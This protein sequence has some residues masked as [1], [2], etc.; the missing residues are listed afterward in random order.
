MKSYGGFPAKML[1][2]AVPEPFFSHVMPEISDI[3]E[4]K[5]TLTI[6]RVLYRK[7]GSLRF[8]TMGELSGDTG[9]MK[10]L[11]EEAEVARMTLAAALDKAVERGTILRMTVAGEA[12]SVEIYFLNTD[13]DRQMMAKLRSGEI[14]VPEFGAPQLVTTPETQTVPDVFS[15][16]E[17]NIG[18]L[19]PIVADELRD[20]LKTYPEAWIRDAIREATN[21]SKRKWSYVSAILE[22]WGSEGR[23]DG[24][25]DGTY[26]GYPKKADPDKY[27]KGKYGHMVQR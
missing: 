12:T 17:E 15:V 13:S 21:N 11:A 19:T 24:K 16:Y 1:F 22:R 10:G 7:R 23:S 27:I 4:L 6:F 8:V 9:L 14:A 2:T 18:L 20:A 26:R 5:T 3:A 25:S